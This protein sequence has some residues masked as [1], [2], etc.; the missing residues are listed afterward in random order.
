MS[1][2]EMK[3]HIKT[4]IAAGLTA[5][6]LAHTVATAATHTWNG[7]GFFGNITR[8]W[9]DPFNWTGGAPSTNEEPPVILV[10]PDTASEKLS[11]NDL[12]GLVVDEIR[13]TGSNYTLFGRNPGNIV[14]LRNG[15]LVSSTGSGNKVHGSLSLQLS[16]GRNPNEF[17]VAPSQTLRIESVLRGA[18]GFSKIG[19]GIL[20]L[21]PIVASLYTGTTRVEA[22][23]LDLGA[24]LFAGTV[25]I[26]GDLIVGASGGG[27]AAEV[28][29]LST[30][31]IADGAN[32]TVNDSGILQTAGFT[33]TLGALTL[34]GGRLYTDGAVV[35]L[36]QDVQSTGSSIIDGAISLGSATRNF[37]V[38]DSL[39]VSAIVS[40]AQGAGIVKKGTG[41][42]S[43]AGANTFSGPVNVETGGV[44]ADHTKAFGTTAGGVRIEAGAHL[45][46]GSFK[47]VSGESLWMAG[48]GHGSPGDLFFGNNSFWN[49][50]VHLEG[51]TWVEANGSPSMAAI[52]GAISGPGTLIKTG[53]APLSLGGSEPNT[54]KGGLQVSEGDLYLAKLS[55][56]PVTGGPITVGQPV[57]IPGDSRVVLNSS[58]QIPDELPIFILSSGIL[59]VNAVTE[60]VLAIRGKG[61]IEIKGGQFGVEFGEG[62]LNVFFE[63]SLKG[64]AGS[65]FTK[66]GNGTF[67]V[68]ASGTYAGKIDVQGG[69][70]PLG[71]NLPNAL[72]EVGSGA[73]LS[74]E[75]TVDTLTVKSGGTVSPGKDGPGR[76]IVDNDL[77]LEAGSRYVARV[78]GTTPGSGHDQ[79]RVSDKTTLG[80][81][82]LDVDVLTL[83][84]LG[85][86][87]P[88]IET[89]SV[90]VTSGNFTGVP[91]NATL[92]L[93]AGNFTARYNGGNG[94]EFV[95]LASQ[96]RPVI[97][98]FSADSPV[99]EGS[100]MTLNGLYEWPDV[101][102]TLRLVVN[103]GDGTPPTTNNVKGGTF[104]V[105][106]KYADDTPT[107]LP[108]SPRNINAVL[109][110][111]EGLAST[112]A[113][114]A[115][116][117]TN[118]APV[119]FPGPPKV[120]ASGEPL[121]QEIEIIDPGADSLTAQVSYG[122][123]AQFQ[124]LKVS[125]GKT[126]KL[127][128][129]YPGDGIF[130]I[131]M[132]VSDDDLGEFTWE[133]PVFVGLKL[134]IEPAPNNQVKLS[135]SSRFPGL[136]V[137]AN[138]EVSA[139]EWQTLQDAPQLIND[140]YTVLLPAGDDTRVF[141]L[142]RP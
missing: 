124:S 142:V 97:N 96:A 21:D 85:Q 76:I 50:P 110:P 138:S 40:G 57:G 128:H 38:T 141:R 129:T 35:T 62:F 114:T 18:G 46:I 92:N 111:L 33:D 1:S 107:G 108:E 101:N 12:A 139:S 116:L 140:R 13:I 25:A 93:T 52:N 55:G 2:L 49:G 82:N 17:N 94:N 63:G 104:A 34:N 64:T 8:T 58:H 134:A 136:L 44:V 88:L 43:L 120:L 10:F 133:W 135:W 126:V 123:T 71:G 39:T 45:T 26:P 29:Y 77:N 65:V 99:M 69:H 3:T 31:Q 90:Q 56:V 103:W 36:S 47:G 80:G 131:K 11:T 70:L 106:H 42:L 15:G 28:R 132:K 37:T 91:P 19:G 16:S 102:A 115:V 109:F 112:T 6:T 20:V 7:T 117:V 98:R 59:M 78:H 53:P 14:T 121:D 32:I 73:T 95:L 89:L 60:K 119:F 100:V 75:F 130:M 118:R 84:P 48:G 79:I 86:E 125:P 67:A 105:S 74:G 27:A 30:D 122:D 24:G 5:I 87:I 54:L 83:V 9:S 23:R 41:F 66:A 68:T 4:S 137:Q 22:G 51:V 81:A 72:V 113:S 127:N 61:E